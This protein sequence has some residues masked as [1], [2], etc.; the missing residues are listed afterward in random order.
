MNVYRAVLISGPP[1]IGKTTS[2]HLVA[3][4]EGYAPLEFNASDTRSKKLIENMLQDT[5]NNKSLDSWYSGGSA[6]S[7]GPD[8]PRI[9]ERTVLI[10]DEVDGM[11]VVTEEV[12]EPSMLS[13]RRQRCR[14][15]ASA[16]IDEIKR[17]DLLSI[18]PTT[19][20]SVNRMLPKSSH[21][22]FSIAFKE[23]LK[24]PGEVMAQLIEAAQSDIRSV[25]NML[26]T[27]KL[28][29]NTMDFDES[30]SLG[31]ENAKP[32]LHT[33]FSLYSELSSPYMFSATSRKTLNDKADL[34]FQDHSFVPL[35]VAEN[36]VKL[37]PLLLPRRL[38]LVSKSST[39]NCYERR[40]RVSAMAIWSIE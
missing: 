9:H 30:K 4:M 24:I 29:K 33:P 5:I 21:V 23:K 26:S 10:M 39:S 13:S 37:N 40:P 38:V 1:G 11:S 20:A 16:T 32:G 34:Y 22:C 35:M 25:I 18:P 6:K 7:L 12:L 17:C 27:W 31:A 8:V 15:F 36:Y 28:S 14:S 2:A 3:K 19:S